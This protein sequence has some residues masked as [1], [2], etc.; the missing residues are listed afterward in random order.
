MNQIWLTLMSPIWPTSND[1]WFGL[2]LMT[3]IWAT[4]VLLS[5]IWHT[6]TEFRAWC[7]RCSLPLF[8]RWENMKMKKIKMN[9]PLLDLRGF[10]AG[11]NA[12]PSFSSIIG[13]L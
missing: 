9:W 4:T 5:H 7:N 6:T 8:V 10:A 13:R 2:P 1:S 11:K 3:Q 12:A